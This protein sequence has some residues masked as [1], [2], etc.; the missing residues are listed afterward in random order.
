MEK[1]TFLA[2]VPPKGSSTDTTVP[3]IIKEALPSLQTIQ[4]I[5]NYSKALKVHKR[6]KGKDFIEYLAN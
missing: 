5:L 2:S 3:Q 4:N 6:S 1:N